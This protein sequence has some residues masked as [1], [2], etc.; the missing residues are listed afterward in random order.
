MLL[1]IVIIQT[2]MHFLK[3]QNII[4][5]I[6]NIDFWSNLF[7]TLTSYI[8]NDIHTKSLNRIR[9]GPG[10]GQMEGESFFMLY[11]EPQVA[12]QL[13]KL[14]GHRRGLHNVWSLVMVKRSEW[15]LYY[16]YIV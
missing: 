16:G 1:Y 3:N 11:P 10:Y 6:C 5:N 13:A 2:F 8:T 9:V 14:A 7:V 4:Y 15:C 12:V